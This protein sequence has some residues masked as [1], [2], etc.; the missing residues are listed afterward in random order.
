[1]T[2]SNKHNDASSHIVAPPSCCQYSEQLCLASGFAHHATS[3][4]A[5]NS[6][7]Q[8]HS[9]SKKEADGRH[10]SDKR[11]PTHATLDKKHSELDCHNEHGARQKPKNNNNN[12]YSSFTHMETQAH[13]HNVLTQ[14]SHI[15]N[16]KI[17]KIKVYWV[18][19]LETHANGQCEFEGSWE[20]KKPWSTFIRRKC[21]IWC[22][23]VRLYW[24]PVSQPRLF[25]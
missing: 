9:L 11:R 8:W 13:R 12:T 23:L 4:H 6:S 5:V 17:R 10:Q 15:P 7:P 1:M 25:C 19:I 22:S 16:A 24:A 21:T 14:T 20:E 18:W 2:P 3:H